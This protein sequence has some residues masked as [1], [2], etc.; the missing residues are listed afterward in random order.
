MTALAEAGFRAVAP[1]MRGF[2][3]TSAPEDVAA[4]TI[5]H[6]VGDMVALVAALGENARA[7]RRARL[8]RAGR[9]A[10]RRCCGRISFPP[11]SR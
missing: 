5:L 9:L 2:G 7:D 1:D 3:R 11:S 10:L 4:Y 6:N 8:G